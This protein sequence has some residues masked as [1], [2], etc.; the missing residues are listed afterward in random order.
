MRIG[1]LLLVAPMLAHSESCLVHSQGQGVD[2]QICQHNINIPSQMFH[3]EFCQPHLKGQKINISYSDQCPS[4]AF[5]LCKNAQ[6]GS[7]Y[8]QDIY[9]Y[10]V[11][12]DARFLQPVCEQQYHGHWHNLVN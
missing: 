7:F 12:S 1:W 3:D 5:A 11:A 2:V 9:Y 10:G 8:Q 6:A 4:Q